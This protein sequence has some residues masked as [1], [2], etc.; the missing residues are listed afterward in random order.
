MIFRGV[1]CPLEPAPMTSK[2]KWRLVWK[3]TTVYSKVSFDEPANAC[4]DLGRKLQVRVEG[5]ER[6][7]AQE[8]AA[9]LQAWVKGGPSVK[10]FRRKKKAL[11]AG[12][13]MLPGIEKQLEVQATPQMGLVAGDQ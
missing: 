2:A 5:K 4:N 13:K 8:D 7:K 12:F 6:R 9:K 11:P 1:F 10:V 3:T